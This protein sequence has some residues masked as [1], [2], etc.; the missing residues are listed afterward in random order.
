MQI[1]K[2]WQL[3]PTSAGNLYVTGLSEGEHIFVCTV[4][5]HCNAGMHIKVVVS[6]D[7][8]GTVREQAEGTTHLVRP[9]I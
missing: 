5:G 2:E 9:G 7:S 6:G 1:E 4:S 3:E 8:T